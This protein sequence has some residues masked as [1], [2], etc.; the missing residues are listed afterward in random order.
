MLLRRP[1][2]PHNSTPT[3]VELSGAVPQNTHYYFVTVHDKQV[4]YIM[5]PSQRMSGRQGPT[6][7]SNTATPSSSAGTT[8]HIR[9]NSLPT[10]STETPSTVIRPGESSD[11]AVSPTDV[12]ES[13]DGAS[14]CYRVVDWQSRDRST[15][16]M[17]VLYPIYLVSFFV[18]KLIRY[19]LTPLRI[20][21]TVL[22]FFGDV[23][24]VRAHQRLQLRQ[25]EFGDVVI[26]LVWWR[27]VTS[28]LSL[29]SLLSHGW[30]DLSPA[31]G[32]WPPFT[33]EQ[34]QLVLL[35]ISLHP[36]PTQWK[37]VLSIYTRA[38]YMRL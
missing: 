17:V 37:Y 5:D 35:W 8:R 36:S 38:I 13:T 22:D 11:D 30:V 24:L 33:R 4:Y 7:P 18:G 3:K 34:V 10:L 32:A 9:F 31:A 25:R 1:A 26:K 16:D 14:E 28:V 29:R 19:V 27:W 21:A 23:A 20:A 15:W 6:T 2:A 12:S